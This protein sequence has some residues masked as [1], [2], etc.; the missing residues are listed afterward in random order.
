MLLAR[1]IE[2]DGVHGLVASAA[3]GQEHESTG[4]VEADAVDLVFGLV[5]EPGG[6]VYADRLIRNEG[7][8]PDQ[9]VMV[10]LEEGM[11]NAVMAQATLPPR[12][13][14][15]SWMGMLTGDGF[16]GAAVTVGA[17]PSTRWIMVFYTK[18]AKIAF[19][20]NNT[21]TWVFS[22]WFMKW[23]GSITFVFFWI[24][25]VSNIA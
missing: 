13:T 23:I 10:T 4:I 25:F 9:V 15:Y 21:F 18:M 14:D 7:E 8:T 20:Y 3:P 16:Y 24:S 11:A 12:V 6:R 22:K 2:G 17:G 19:S 5:D 1:I